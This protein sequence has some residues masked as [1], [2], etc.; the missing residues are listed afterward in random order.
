MMRMKVG[1]SRQEATDRDGNVGATCEIEV[2]IPGGTPDAEVLRIRDHWLNLCEATV[3]EELDRLQNGTARP[4]SASPP[5]LST[6][7]AV[8]PKA[9]VSAAGRPEYRGPSPAGAAAPRTTMTTGTAI[10]IVT[11]TMRG[12]RRSTAGSSSA[13]RPSRSP[14]PRAW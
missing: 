4:A 12:V 13:G 11:A 7:P 3:D 5:A 8:R 10:A 9:A 6:A 14:T 1:V 2:E